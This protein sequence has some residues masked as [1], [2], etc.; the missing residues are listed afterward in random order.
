MADLELQSHI[1]GLLLLRRTVLS[2]NQQTAID[3]AV[4][5]LRSTSAS[6]AT[7]WAM[8]LMGPDD[9]YA[10]PNQAEALRVANSINVQ[11]ASTTPK[12]YAVVVP[13][14]LS[15]E[16]HA[17]DVTTWDSEWIAEFKPAEEAR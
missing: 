2:V 4:A 8:H 10:A 14:T 6:G 12:P 17:Q 7:L 9:V 11:F 3:A 13:W 5:A 1:D 15:A 16:H